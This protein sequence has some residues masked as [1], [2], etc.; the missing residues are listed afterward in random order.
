MDDLTHTDF[1]GGRV[2]AWQPA[3]GY[4]AGVDA[5]MLAAAVDA[6]QGQEVLELGCGVG[7]ASLCLLARVPGLRATGLEIQADY[8]DLARRNAAEAGAKFEVVTG[9][10]AAMPAGLRDRQFDHVFA[11][12]PYFLRDASVSAQDPGR[13][14]ALGGDTPL[15]AWIEAAAKR[16]KPRGFVTFIQRVERL[17]ELLCTMQARLG[18]LQLM[19]ILPRQG[20]ESQLFLIRGR[21]GGRAAFRLHAGILMHE[22]ET[23]QQDG[24][25][26]T[27]EINSVLREGAALPFPG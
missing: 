10:L 24:E 1:L 27:S 13:D 4:R 9:D 23:H 3:R 22:G 6:Q 2:R 8:A 20:R 18:S 17:P 7:V 25:S 14:I 12:P 19:P 5:V 15:E 16:V 11:N 21:K 26:Y